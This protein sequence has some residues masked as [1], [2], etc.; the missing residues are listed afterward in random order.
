MM[1]SRLKLLQIKRLI[2]LHFYELYFRLPE[3]KI[4]RANQE[5]THEIHCSLR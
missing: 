3:L 2:G 4:I 5:S 1:L